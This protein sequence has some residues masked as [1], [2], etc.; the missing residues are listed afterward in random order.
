MSAGI[1][2]LGGV[3]LG[4]KQVEVSSANF[5]Y[6]GS[7]AILATAYLAGITSINGA[8]IGGMLISAGAFVPTFSNYMFAGTNIDSYIGALTGL[9][10]IVTAIVHPEGIAPFFGEGIRHAGNWL[11][12][13]IPGAATIRDDYRGSRGT[14]VKAFMALLVVGNAFFLYNAKFVENVYLWVLIDVVLVWLVVVAFS[15]VLGGVSPTF[16][17]AGVAWIDWAKRFGP[18][19]LAG[20]VAGWLIWPI[21]VDT[22]SKLWM[23][24]VGAGIALFIRS[25]VRQ[26]R[27]SAEKE[28]AAGA[29]DSDDTSEPSPEPSLAEVN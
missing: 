3:M 7:L 9:G 25:I 20:Y 17:E 18:T 2:G 14:M 11:V 22:Y 1:A 26:I 23:P 27:G 6:G 13:A 24:L 29:D 4:F 19:A 15:L 8:I 28:A 5:V 21:R 16:G 12:G 10:I